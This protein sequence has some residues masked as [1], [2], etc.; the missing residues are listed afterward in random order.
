MADSYAKVY[1]Q[2]KQKGKIK[3][4]PSHKGMLHSDLGV[5]KDKPIPEGKLKKAENSSDPAE[6]K[7][8]TFAENAKHWNH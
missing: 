1:A 2:R 4:K 3:I 6:R 7:R 8:A 5:A